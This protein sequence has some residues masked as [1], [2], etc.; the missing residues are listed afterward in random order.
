MAGDSK[1]SYTFQ[2]PSK[3]LP[4]SISRATLARI[5]SGDWK[6]W[7]ILIIVHFTILRKLSV[8]QNL[9]MSEKSSNYP[10]QAKKSHKNLRMWDFFCTFA[11]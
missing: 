7:Q 2:Q 5:L 4:N 3:N 1:Q 6:K 8:G 10:S 11:P 9:L